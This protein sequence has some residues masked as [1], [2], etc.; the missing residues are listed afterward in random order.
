MSQWIKY[1]LG[2]NPQALIISQNA[3]LTLRGVHCWAPMQFSI[4]WTTNITFLSCLVFPMGSGEKHYYC[5]YVPDRQ[6]MAPRKIWVT[7]MV[8]S[9]LKM[10]ELVKKYDQIHTTSQGVGPGFQHGWLKIL[11][12]FCHLAINAALDFE[13]KSSDNMMWILFHFGDLSF[14]WIFWL[15]DSW[16]I[17]ICF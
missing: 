14:S 12:F 2:Q 9:I 15:I 17:W 3:L 13:L 1:W 8:T 10:E 5:F 11:F 6:L 4:K 16:C 7:G